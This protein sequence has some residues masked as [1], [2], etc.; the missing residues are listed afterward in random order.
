ML[1]I[2]PNVKKLFLLVRA[3]DAS[4]AAKRLHEEIINKSLFGVLREREGSNIMEKIVA[5]AGDVSCENLGIRD[6]QMSKEVQEEI[7]IIVNSAA[8]TNFNERYDLSL[9]INTFGAANLMS[10]AN[11]CA[12]AKIFLHVSTA[13]VCGEREG[14]IL[15]K[16][17]RMGET[18]NGSHNLDINAEQQLAMGL[19]TELRGKNASDREISNAM[20]DFGVHRAR[21]HGWPNTY[22]FTKAM[23]EMLL[24]HLKKEHLPL[25]VFRPT[26]ITSTLKE[27]FSGW[28]ENFR[29]LDSIAFAY[30]KGK[31]KFFLADPR[32]IIDII[33]V[34]MVVNA[35]IMG[36]VINSHHKQLSP[37]SEGD[38][39]IIYH[40]GS[41]SRNPITFATI[42]SLTRQYFVKNPWINED[43]RPVKVR[44]ARVISSISNFR[45]YMTLRYLVFIKVLRLASSVLC[46]RKHEELYLN[47][48]RKI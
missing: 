40:L 20:K 6:S 2:Q 34:D 28:I 27:P 25:L 36:T 48:N 35:M 5:V 11:K 44:K 22:A 10:F 47:M 1:R 45:I 30:G 33:P 46:L 24:G 29:T 15:E 14:L 43:G 41:S 19:L 9:A 3:A 13:Y 12:N 26:I 4:L 16:P 38:E 21:I 42:Q 31:L 32:A 8:T 37:H 23:G 39:P 17:F 18:L 7:D